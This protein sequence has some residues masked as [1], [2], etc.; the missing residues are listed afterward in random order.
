MQATLLF[1]FRQNENW[2]MPT[3]IFRAKVRA[4]SQAILGSKIQAND[5][6]IELPTRRRQQGLRRLSRVDDF[7]ISFQSFDNARCGRFAIFDK[8]NSPLAPYRRELAID[9]R[10]KAE[11]HVGSSSHTHFVCQNL[12]ACE[13][14]YA[15]DQ[16]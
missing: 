4:Q 7:V 16:G 6:E 13:I 14:L 12:K 1:S 5:E 8:E 15:C 9:P 11:L 10:A 3:T 2:Q